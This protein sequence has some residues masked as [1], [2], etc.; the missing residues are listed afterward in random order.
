MTVDAKNEALN[1][2][3]AKWKRVRDCVAGGDAVRKTGREYLPELSGQEPDEYRAYSLRASFYEATGR[4]KEALT[5]LVFSRPPLFEAPD[6]LLELYDD[7]DLDGTRIEDFAAYLLDEALETGR[8]FILANHNGDPNFQGSL[9][10]PNGRPFLR[11]YPAES[12]YD[13]RTTTIAGS[14]QLAMI[15]LREVVSIVNPEDEFATLKVE[16][17]RVLDIE[18]GVYRQRVYQLIQ[19]E[20]TKKREWKLV[21]GPIVPIV[22]GKP[23]TVIPG[24]VVTLGRTMDPGPVP[25]LPLADVNLSH[26]RTSADLEHGAHFTGLPT[27]VITGY[28]ADE[29]ETIRIGS[30]EA[31]ILDDKDAKAFYMEFS[32]NGLSTLENLLNR[33]EQ[34]MAALG[35]R[36]LAPEKAQAESGYA[37]D[38]RRTGETASLA[39]VAGA[40]SNA[41]TAALRYAT[42]W[43]GEE[44]TQTKYQLNRIYAAERIDAP[45][46]TALLAALQAGQISYE[47]FFTNLQRGGRIDEETTAE[48][49]KD[50]IAN[51]GPPLGLIEETPPNLPTPGNSGGAV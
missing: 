50:K 20:V 11:Y 29:G 9:A 5:G 36:M 37:L 15:K 46:I 34:H 10:D 39:R 21:E 2:Y 24:A 38:V 40:V 49:E 16:Q 48:D 35:A 32:G 28:V 31:L 30:S 14:T 6:A 51:D 26:F 8:G 4:T 13:W 23:W 42:A 1:E 44:P 43:L 33:K 22:N 27:P 25:L 7:I 19:D 45:T 41:L 47:T 3:G 18:T 12:I 17:F